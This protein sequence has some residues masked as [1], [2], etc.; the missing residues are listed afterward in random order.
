MA[1]QTV[2]RSASPLVELTV[3]LILPALILMQLSGEARLGPI[4][5]LLAALA[6]P[7]GWGVREFLRSRKANLFAALGF[8]S[9][10]LTGGI[11]LLALDPTWL[12]VKEAAI[13]AILGLVVLASAFTRYPLARVLLFSPKLMQVDRIQA[14]LAAR[15]TRGAFERKLVRATWILAASFAFSAVMNYLLARWIVTSLPGTE[16]FNAELGRLALISYPVIA[17]PSMLIMLAALFYLVRA[18]RQLA[19]LTLSDILHSTKG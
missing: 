3:T 1:D 14:A 17:L 9:V 12:A 15:G 7:L 8:V 11:G 10:L 5:A 13:P 16:A 6:L 4:N 2:S 18:L 19:G